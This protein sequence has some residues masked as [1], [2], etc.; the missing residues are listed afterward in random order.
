[1]RLAHAA[2]PIYLTSTTNFHTTFSRN[3]NPFLCGPATSL[4]FT[5][6]AI[7]KP[8][9]IIG[10]GHTYPW[11]ATGYK[12]TDGNKTLLVFIRHGVKWSAGKPAVPGGTPVR[13]GRTDAPGIARG[14]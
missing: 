12:W 13:P 1:V 8:L 3:F 6:G 7:Y 14:L 5:C 9:I 10:G 11:L 4:D 2:S